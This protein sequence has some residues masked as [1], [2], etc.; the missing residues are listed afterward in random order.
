MH[1]NIIPDLLPL[2]ADGLTSPETEAFI[3]RHLQDCPAC[4][5]IWEHLQTPIESPQAEID[6]EIIIRALRRQKK[7]TL[8]ITATVCILLSVGLLLALWLPDKTNFLSYQL[9]PDSSDPELI[10]SEE[11]RLA[12]T[13]E[14]IALGNALLSHP[15]IAEGKKNENDP[16]SLSLICFSLLSGS[17]CLP[18]RLSRRFSFTVTVSC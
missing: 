8:W 6:G 10:L 2:Y 17:I 9:K 18:M 4:R 14:E 16:H 3:L 1:C 11:P 12:V 15:V 7:R 13:K 5:K